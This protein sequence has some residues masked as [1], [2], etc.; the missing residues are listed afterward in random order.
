MLNGSVDTRAKVR[1]AC[2]ETSTGLLVR[3]V[4]TKELCPHCGAT[5]WDDGTK[6]GKC[7]R[8]MPKV[9]RMLGDERGRRGISGTDSFRRLAS[10][11]TS[12]VE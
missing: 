1:A 7:F 4:V 5:R 2:A 6:C 9:E 12:G 8:Y 3:M 11:P 10:E